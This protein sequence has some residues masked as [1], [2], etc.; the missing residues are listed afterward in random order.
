MSAQDPTPGA[1]TVTELDIDALE[2][3]ARSCE[4]Y[5]LGTKIVP[6]MSAK[7]SAFHAHA[8]DN[9]LALIANIRALRSPKKP[10]DPPQ[11]LWEKPLP[12]PSNEE[13]EALTERYDIPVGELP[14][15]TSG[16]HRTAASEA[17]GEV[18]RHRLGPDGGY[19][20]VGVVEV[21]R[22]TAALAQAYAEVDEG[23]AM[24]ADLL[25]V[26]EAVR[27]LRAAL[28]KPPRDIASPVLP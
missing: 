14:G 9:V 5:D 3:E 12:R 18:Y 11:I 25:K 16:R 28:E 23:R 10:Y 6:E 8:R 22:A 27:N 2:A 13:L 20:E 15:V 17:L 21:Q 19:P 1:D 26:L 4:P 7:T 24:R